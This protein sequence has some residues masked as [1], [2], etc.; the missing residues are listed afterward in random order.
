MQKHIALQDQQQD[1]LSTSQI[2]FK[3]LFC[4]YFQGSAISPFRIL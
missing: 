1:M 4:S 3:H 2:W